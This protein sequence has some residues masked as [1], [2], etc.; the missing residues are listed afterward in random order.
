MNHDIDIKKVRINNYRQSK[1]D[2]EF[3]L[4]L[5]V[6]GSLIDA[7]H[8]ETV[9]HICETWG[10]GTFHVGMRHTLNIP[11]IK[12][13]YIDEVNKYIADYMEDVHVK[14]CG[15]D[16]KLGA[17]Y[18]TIGARNI[19]ACIGNI[20][21]IKA[22]VNTQDL[23]N[24]LDKVIFPS[25]YHIKMSIAGCPN[26]CGKAHFNDFGIIGI[27]SME[28]DADRCIGCGACVEACHHHAT[29]V[30]QLKNE[31][32]EKDTCCCVGCGECT[33]ACPTSAWTRNP[34]KYYRILVG[35]RTGKQYPRMGKTFVNW[36]TEEDV[37][38]ILSNWQKFSAWTLDNKPMYLHG[39]H[40]IDRAGYQKFKEL[41]LDGVTLNPKATVAERIYWAETEYKAQINVKPL[42]EHHT[43]GPQMVTA[44]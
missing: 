35:G 4:Q 28:Y 7:K 9:Q 29:G 37:I 32:V 40:L 31:K 27:A 25:H 15:I 13:E 2:G 16:M 10:N 43:A 39:G 33:L 5:R 19:M 21:C 24:K 23:A 8:L 18:P 14:M 12:Y 30:L 20:H 11:G 22:N 3:M 26:D 36:A 34:Q 42:S 44:D 1:V 6:P 41:M 17:G 38:A